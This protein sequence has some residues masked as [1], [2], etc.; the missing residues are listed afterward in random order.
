MN[1]PNQPTA[2]RPLDKWF[3]PLLLLTAAAYAWRP[4]MSFDDFWN[5]AAVGRWMMENKQFPHETLFLWTAKQSWVAHSWGTQLWFGFLM[6]AGEVWGPRL[7]LVFAVIV[8]TAVYWLLWKLW[9]RNALQ[10]QVWVFAPLLFLLAIGGSMGRYAV[11]PELFTALFLTILIFYL[12]ESRSVRFGWPEVGLMLMFVI[13]VNVHGAFLMGLVLL[14]LAALGDSLQDRFDKRA[15][16]LWVLLFLCA[17][18]FICNPYGTDLLVSFRQVNSLAF[19]AIDEWK[20][21]WAAPPL[22]FSAVA[23]ALI[24]AIVAAGVWLINPQRRWAHGLWLLFFITAF[25]QARRQLWLLA[26]VCL[27]V[28]AANSAVF[29][30]LAARF[31]SERRQRGQ[32]ILIGLICLNFF[33]GPFLDLLRGGPHENDLPVA[34][35]DHIERY[36]PPGRLFNGMSNAAYLAWRFGKKKSLYIDHLQAHGDDLI[37]DYIDISNATRRGRGLLDEQKIG[38]IILRNPRDLAPW[39]RLALYLFNAPDWELVFHDNNAA[40]WVRKTPEYAAL[41]AVKNQYVPAELR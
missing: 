7:A 28:M 4:L 10:K 39:P 29:E 11:R 38:Y 21:F 36:N 8:V 16:K 1:E 6:R 40:L 27:A 22:E 26:I 9:Q 20:P 19:A 18:T 34:L 24:L 13:W 30:K 41:R 2:E 32:Q 35:C 12:S 37:V 15:R 17:A 25:L 14:G 33:A 5:H 3:L 31:N 23:S